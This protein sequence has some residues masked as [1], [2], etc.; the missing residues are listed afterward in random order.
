MD[1]DINRISNAS[2]GYIAANCHIFDNIPNTSISREVLKEAI[3]GTP[4]VKVGSTSP[5]V[6]V[7]AGMHGNEL[8]PQIAAMHLIHKLVDLNEKDELNGTAFVVPFSA[9]KSTM[10]NSRCFDGV[11]LNR[12]SATEGSLSNDI[13]AKTK[14]LKIKSVGDFHSTAPNSMPGKEGIFCTMKPSPE[15]FQLGKYIAD[16]IISEL[17]FYNEAGNAY[18]GA[19]EDECNMVGIPAVTCEVLSPNGSTDKITH[20]RSLEQM[21]SYLSYFGIISNDI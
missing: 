15:S 17:L 13:L 18:K 11:D 2:G 4:L 9:P 12:V 10:V 20:K 3:K 6:M 8:P 14:E 19:I 1:F 21:E 7:I 16:S 5:K